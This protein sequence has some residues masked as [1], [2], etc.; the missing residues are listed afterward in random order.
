M[1]LPAKN[2]KDAF[3]ACDP[4]TPLEA[5]RFWH[6]TFRKALA[7]EELERRGTKAAA[8]RSVGMG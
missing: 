8:S 2:L 4:A 7:A 3:N 5:D 1:Q 6:R